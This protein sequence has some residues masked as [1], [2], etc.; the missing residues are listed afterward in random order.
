VALA[1]LNAEASSRPDFV[2]VVAERFRA[3]LPLVEWLNVP[4]AAVPPRARA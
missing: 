4:L 2:D 3:F 1:G